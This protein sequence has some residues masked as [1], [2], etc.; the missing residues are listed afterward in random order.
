MHACRLHAYTPLHFQR[1]RCNIIVYVTELKAIVIL[2]PSPLVNVLCVLDPDA[3][4]RVDQKFGEW[5]HWSV[6][7]IPG[8]DISKGEVL[9][10]YVGSGPPNGTSE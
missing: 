5:H 6:V 8:E 1:I 9:A 10:E 7:N 4:S 3:P 2:S